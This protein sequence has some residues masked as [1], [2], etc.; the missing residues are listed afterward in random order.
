MTRTMTR[1]V[2]GIAAAAGGGG[3]PS[4]VTAEGVLSGI[5]ALAQEV[6]GCGALTNVPV[7]IQGLGKVGMALAGLLVAEGATV[8]ACDVSVEAV[9]AARCTLRICTVEPEAIH[10]VTFAIFAPRGYCFLLHDHTIPRLNSR[11]VA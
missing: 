7:A 11:I 4:P 10:D 1:H 9:E 8:T 5:R 2:A 6:L 3:D